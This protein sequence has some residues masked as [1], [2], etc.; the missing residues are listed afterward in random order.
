MSFLVGG[1]IGPAI[2]GFLNDA[3]GSYAASLVAAA[4]VLG[5]SA[6]VAWRLRHVAPWS[7]PP[8]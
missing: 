7:P 3:T 1:A 4:I 6:A 2:S 8:V 5:A